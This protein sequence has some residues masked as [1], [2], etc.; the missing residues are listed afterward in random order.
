MRHLNLLVHQIKPC[1][2]LVLVLQV[3]V[4]MNVCVCVCYV[5]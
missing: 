5:L 4:V 3:L 2:D 1:P